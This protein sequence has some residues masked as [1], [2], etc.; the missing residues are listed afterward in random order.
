MKKSKIFKIVFLISFLPYILLILL[1]IHSAIYGHNIYAFFGNQYI[2]TIYGIEAFKEIVIYGVLFMCA[3]FI[4]P[5][6]LII[7]II[8]I[9]RC[10]KNKKKTRE[11]I[12]Q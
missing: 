10:I 3:T 7:Q 5:I 1:A 6:S 8:Y 12:E 2:R 11:N 9:A 4:L